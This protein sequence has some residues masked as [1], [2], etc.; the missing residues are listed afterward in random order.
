MSGPP[1]VLDNRTGCKTTWKKL[2]LGLLH[3]KGFHWTRFFWPARE[4]MRR[5]Q[6]PR[7]MAHEFYG[8]W[9]CLRAMLESPLGSGRNVDLHRGYGDCHSVASSCGC[10]GSGHLQFA[11]AHV[12]HGD[13]AECVDLQ[14]NRFWSQRLGV[15]DAHVGAAAA[16]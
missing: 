10:A 15:S 16:D 8:P 14:S 4:N 7:R 1:F 13:F 9:N 2:A 5:C 12:W 6:R 11:T 3:R